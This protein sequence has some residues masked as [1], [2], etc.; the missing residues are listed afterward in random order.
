M[1]AQRAISMIRGC[2][3]DYDFKSV[4]I[5]GFSAGGF[6]AGDVSNA[7]V[8]AYAAIDDTDKLSF[9][10]DFAMLI[11]AASIKQVPVNATPTFIAMAKD[12]PCVKV[13]MAESYH[14]RLMA[15]GDTGHELH[16]YAGGKH[17][18]GDC[19]LYV[20]GNSWQ[21]VCAW[22]L[23]AQLFIENIIGLHRPL[24]PM[25]YPPANLSSLV[26]DS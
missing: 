7:P 14:A 24:E 17:G 3:S 11:Y 25:S 18:F 4:G 20:T 21:P 23:N 10:P 12:D 5:M 16:I 6:L 26:V 15:A 13:S 1:D 2:S 19:S 9:R 22:T 8:R